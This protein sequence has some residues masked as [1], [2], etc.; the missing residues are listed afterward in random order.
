VVSVTAH[1]R[2]IRVKLIDWCACHGGDRLIDLYY[3]AF[4]ALGTPSR[5]T[6]RW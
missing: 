2:T 6:V 4:K 3:D 5:V 1:G